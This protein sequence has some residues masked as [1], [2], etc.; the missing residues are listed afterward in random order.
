MAADAAFGD[1]PGFPHPVRFFGWAI[2][3]AERGARAFARGSALAERLF[4][5]AIAAATCGGTWTLAFSA[6]E[7]LRGKSLLAS[8]ACDVL[9][10][11]TAIAARDLLRESGAVREALQSGDLERAR[12]RV[13]RI[14]G[15]DTQRLDGDGVARATIETLAESL[16]DGIIAPMLAL[17]FGGVPLALAFKAASTMDSMIGHIEPP[18]TNLGFAAAKLDDVLCWLPARVA[19]LA[20]ALVAP[21]AGGSTKD[22]YAILLA[23]GARHPSP[24]AGRPEAAMA[25]ALGVR[26]G[27]ANAYGGVLAD[28][29]E[30]GAVFGSPHVFDIRRAEEIVVAA[31]AVSAAFCF[32]VVSLLEAA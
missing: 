9:L 31:T 15:R 8:E 5:F 22:A 25:G 12:A 11:W 10:G 4:G 26:L 16:C 6:R 27:G 18:Y 7:L 20:I 24:N 1:P 19:A 14:V 13:S 2:A 21:V 23:D 17:A 32:A 30:L 3:R 28:R 29:A